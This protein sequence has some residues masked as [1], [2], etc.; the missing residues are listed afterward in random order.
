MTSAAVH[1]ETIRPLSS[2]AAGYPL[3]VERLTV[4][5]GCELAIVGHNGS[6]KT[7]LLEALLGLRPDYGTDVTLLGQ[8]QP[9]SPGTKAQIGVCFQAQDFADGVRVGDIVRLH[10][11]LYGGRNVR[12]FEALNLQ[13]IMRQKYRALSVGQRQRINL[14]FGL[15]HAPALAFLDEPDAGLDRS[16]QGVL[17]NILR[18]RRNRKLTTCMVTHAP[19]LIQSSHS[20][21]VL[22]RGRVQ[23]HE[24]V[25][26]LLNDIGEKWK[27][28]LKP[29]D[30]LMVPRIL[31]YARENGDKAEEA[32]NTIRIFSES[33]SAKRM[34]NIVSKYEF[35]S[36]SCDRVRFTDIINQMVRTDE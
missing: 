1:I 20:V 35:D 9:V 30:P 3:K 10:G 12:L 23:L 16:Y 2:S 25:D 28:E 19:D 33:F 5:S 26:S 14:Y 31:D 36:L 32:D 29:S 8:R 7:T 11:R 27:I 18:A 24:T 4:E 6:G 13:E 22:R 17:A 15:A 34:I 21:L